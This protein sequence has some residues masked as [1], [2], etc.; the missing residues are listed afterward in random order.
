MCHA[1]ASFQGHMVLTYMALGATIYKVDITLS[2]MNSHYYRDFNLTMAKHPS[3]S[4][5]RMM[6]RLLAFLYSAHDDLEFTK[7]LS[8]TDEPELWQKNY[9]GEIVQWVELGEPDEKRIRQ[10][11]GKSEGVSVFTSQNIE[12]VDKWFNKIK[13]KIPKDKVKIHHLNV[14]ENGPVDRFVERGM[15]LSCMIDGNQM[16]L[17]NDYERIGIE[18]VNK[19]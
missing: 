1:L 18:V 11:A 14:N 15:K 2:N 4:E 3:E 5:E 8:S 13:N 9:S 10:A 12:T 16:F 7:G 19:L 6:Y 17:G